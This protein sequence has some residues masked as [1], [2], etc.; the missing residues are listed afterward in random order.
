[1]ETQYFKY[2][3]HTDTWFWTISTI[4]YGSILTYICAKIIIGNQNQLWKVLLALAPFL[5]ILITLVRVVFY[6]QEY[7]KEAGNKT[8]ILDKEILKL[9][10]EN[11]I[12]KKEILPSEIGHVKLLES[13]GYG[14]PITDFA[15]MEI[16]LK[17][18][19]SIIIPER[20]ANT[21]DLSLLLKG[22]RRIRKK[23]FMNRIKTTANN[24]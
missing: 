22:K 18:G 1:M 10:I 14:P 7:Q 5:F 8:I 21:S 3:K 24:A 23:R 13:Y 20:T 4:I 9:T 11:G 2:K 19:E 12:D 16:V 17:T 6:R 15:Y